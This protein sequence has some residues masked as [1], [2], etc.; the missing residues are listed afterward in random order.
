[1][2]R[3]VVDT[4]VAIAWYLPELFADA[5]HKWRSRLR[6]Q[7]TTFCVPSLHYWEF[8]NVL[9]KNVRREVIN[10]RDAGTIW[11]AHLEARLH[12]VDP[13][14][15][16]VLATAFDYDASAYDSVY[17]ALALELDAPLLTAERS[18]TPWV[19]KLGARAISIA[20]PPS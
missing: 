2:T 7:S 18:S 17:I 15:D 3:F 8:A 16:K 1:M 13:A 4:S 9:R 10:R 6:E 11:S 19:M 5:A 14:R 12:V 20:A